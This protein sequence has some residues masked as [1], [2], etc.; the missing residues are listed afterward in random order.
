MCYDEPFSLSITLPSKQALKHCNHLCGAAVDAQILKVPVVAL[1][2]LQQLS[3]YGGD[4]EVAMGAVA[5]VSVEQKIS[6]KLDSEAAGFL[7][8]RLLGELKSTKTREARSGK[9]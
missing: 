2:P 6:N 9:D 5:L 4:G 1:V 7:S 3:V 8:S